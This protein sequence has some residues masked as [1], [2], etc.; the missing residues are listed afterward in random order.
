MA[1]GA[2]TASRFLGEGLAI[3]WSAALADCTQG[4]PLI[5]VGTSRSVKLE[6]NIFAIKEFK[7]CSTVLELKRIAM[8]SFS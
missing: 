1:W 8:I 7:T 2:A 5:Q 6:K 3:P 4:E